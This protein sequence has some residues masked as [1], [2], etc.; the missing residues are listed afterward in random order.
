MST[1][2]T[3]AALAAIAPA[4]TLLAVAAP[5]AAQPAPPPPPAQPNCTAA[6]LAGVMAGVTASTSAYL[7][8]HPD[9]NDFFTTL[10]GKSRDDQ[11]AAVEDYI[12]ARPDV[13]D[14]LRAIR[15]PSVDFRNRCG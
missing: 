7:F 5:A 1:F 14:A 8:T 13:G 2:L 10:K 11:K 3:R 9:V 12:A 15:Q 6:D 4:A